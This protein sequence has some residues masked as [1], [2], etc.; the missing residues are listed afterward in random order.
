MV[1][2][3][4]PRG[5]NR[6]SERKAKDIRVKETKGKLKAIEVKDMAKPQNSMEGKKKTEDERQKWGESEAMKRAVYIHCGRR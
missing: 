5:N 1:N 2:N 3:P 6:S 4:G